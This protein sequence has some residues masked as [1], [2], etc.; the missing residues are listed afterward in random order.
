MLVFLCRFGLEISRYISVVSQRDIYVKESYVSRRVYKESTDQ[1]F[2]MSQSRR[3]QLLVKEMT[4]GFSMNAV[5]TTPIQ[6]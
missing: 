3:A 4:F 1:V 6:Q 2:T 5:K